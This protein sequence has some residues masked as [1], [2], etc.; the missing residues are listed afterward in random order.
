[1]K[2]ESVLDRKVR[3]ISSNLQL[4]KPSN[5]VF[6][7]FLR[8]FPKYKSTYIL[9]VLRKT[10]YARLDKHKHIYLDYTGGAM[11]A[12]SQIEKHMRFLSDFVLGN[13]HSSNPSSKLATEFVEETR[14]YILNYFNAKDDYY[15]IFTKNATEAYKI[16]GE[17]Y[18]F[19]RDSHLLLSMDNHNSVNGIREYAKTKGAT[20][21]YIPLLKPSLFLD[22]DLLFAKLENYPEK[23]N[24]LFAYPA[25]SNVSGVKHPLEYV[26]L[27]KKQGWDVL[28]DVAAFVPTNQLD[29]SAINTDFAAV[30]FYKIFGYPTGIGCLFVKKDKFCKLRKPWFSGGTITL[31]S[32][33]YDG[34]FLKDAHERFEDG[35]LNYLD[36]PA[37]KVGLEFIKN[38]G[39]DK[40]STRVQC[41]TQWLLQELSLLCHSNQNKLIHI[42]GTTD[43]ERRGGTIAMNFFDNGGFNIP[44]WEIEEKANKH[45]ISLRTGCFCN[46][47]QDET[48]NNI[49]YSDLES[50]FTGKLHGDYFEMLESVNKYRGSVRI[51][52]GSITNFNDVNSFVQ[53]AKSFLN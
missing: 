36:I 2:S 48:N 15:C 49:T 41:L 26:T 17:S 45:N 18:P 5:E 23:T 46:P 19:D 30:S 22:E 6:Q 24:K 31:S 10:E 4:N 35:T 53:F 14:N 47:G 44:F 7:N 40:I 33:N 52:V 42:F 9:D 8:R 21:E 12:L 29:L 16:I 3:V 27:A 38:I 34:H 28:L 11:F 20:F 25:Q 39:M 43:M 51:S 13:P 1:M 32:A 37:I 50:Y